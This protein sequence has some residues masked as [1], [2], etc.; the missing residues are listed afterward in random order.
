MK[1]LN[2]ALAIAAPALMSVG[3][4]P[5]DNLPLIPNNVLYSNIIAF[6]Q[7]SFKLSAQPY[8]DSLFTKK[9][10]KQLAKA[11]KLRTK[12]DD[13][14]IEKA[15]LDTEA[16]DLEREANNN[17]KT[18]K[19]VAKLRA[20]SA[21][22]ELAALKSFET[23]TTTFKDIY[24]SELK[25]KLTDTSSTRGKAANALAQQANELYALA[26]KEKKTVNPEDALS[27]YRSMYNK[28]NKAVEDQELA[29][30][31]LKNDPQVDYTQYLIPD[32]GT[33]QPSP[34]GNIPKSEL[35][36]LRAPQHYDFNADNNIYRI[37][38]NEFVDSLKVSDT[39]RAAMQ[40]LFDA[41]KTASQQMEKASNLGNKADSLRVYA[42]KAYTITEKEYYEQMAQE[43]ELNECSSLVSAVTQEVKTN[44]ALYE[45]YEKYLPKIRKDNPTAKAYENQA[46]NLYNMSK[47]YE[48]LA[49]NQYSKVEKYTILSDGNEIKL[50]AI[51]NMENA[52]ASYLGM[53]LTPDKNTAATAAVDHSNGMP[54]DFMMG[55]DGQDPSDAK[56]NVSNTNT[57][58]Q[59]NN[60]NNTAVTT[61]KAQSKDTVATAKPKQT[62]TT[63]P[64]NKPKTGNTVAANNPKAPAS[65]NVKVPVSNSTAPAVSSWYYTKEDQRLRP[66][67]Y[68]SGTIFT[69]E[70]GIYKEMPEPVEFP[71]VNVFVA[72]K[73]KNQNYMRYY[74]G[75]YKTYDAAL[76]AQ[77]MAKNGGYKS[78][79]ISAFVNGK[80]TNVNTAK[81]SAEKQSGYQSLVQSELRDLSAFQQ[82]FVQPQPEP[83]QIVQSTGSTDAQPLS[84]ISGTAY[85]VQISSVPTLLN[86]S[87]F[88]VNQL[89]YDQN[90]GGLYRYYTGVS[91][92]LNIAKANLQTMKACGYEDAYIIKV[93]NGQN[94]GPVAASNP[95]TASNKTVYRVQIGAYKS[96]LSKEVKNKMDKLKKSY[97]V[98]TSKSGEY[99]V[100]TV[101]DC[102]TRA[103]AD[104]LRANLVKLG[105]TESY[106]VTF[107]NGVKQ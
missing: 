54:T 94:S 46:V 107:I 36:V 86:K 52:I 105:Y 11:E 75:S 14:L 98:H 29:F 67:T 27:I 55:E 59:P 30:A 65:S 90:N 15:A 77:A 17:S 47:S 57:T 66:Y 85:A 61:P 5:T 13:A 93:S 49:A 1:I 45:L 95:Q 16:N 24:T 42:S 106:V 20:K 3:F 43:E 12:C 38:Y 70:T 10:L 78:A 101:G 74:L 53:P 76:A 72:E 41:E 25:N 91:T 21:S 22:K 81:A 80:K 35:P 33:T 96:A 73:L 31:I 4:V 60:N 50:Q 32:R 79:V 58:A 69:V 39:D 6:R 2:L 83:V 9:E 89:F 88:N 63:A 18:L 19:K 100:Y 84:T 44:N 23:A 51:A 56:K 68:P 104:N 92:D 82:Q 71:A 48:K 99:T 37:R 7:G 97:A 62:K 40:K 87:S 34:D 64:S 103:Q 28:W 26:E 8:Y 102:D